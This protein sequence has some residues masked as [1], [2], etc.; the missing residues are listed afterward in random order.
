MART[1]IHKNVVRAWAALVGALL[2]AALALAPQEAEAHARLVRS[3]PPAG[4]RLARPPAVVRLWFSEPVERAFAKAWITD[5]AGKKYDKLA[6]NVTDAKMLQ[7][8]L[9]AIP[10]GTYTVRFRVLSVDGHVVEGTFVFT[11]NPR[12]E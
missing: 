11:V 7:V 10:P 4:T 3:D 9:P 12:P 5:S 1:L 6:K 2:L 8:D